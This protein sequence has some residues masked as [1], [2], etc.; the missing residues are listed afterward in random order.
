M[1]YCWYVEIQIA[2]FSLL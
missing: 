2:S 1:G